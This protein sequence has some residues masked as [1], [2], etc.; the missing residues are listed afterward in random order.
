[1][2]NQERNIFLLD[3]TNPSGFLGTAQTGA[4]NGQYDGS[5]TYFVNIF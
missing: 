5:I 4:L 3:L 2:Y 1:M